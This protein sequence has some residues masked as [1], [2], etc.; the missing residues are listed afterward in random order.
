MENTSHASKP[1]ERTRPAFAVK[2][3]FGILGALGEGLLC[4]EAKDGQVVLEP[5]IE[6]RANRQARLQHIPWHVHVRCFCV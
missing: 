2:L 5:W 1:N 3:G 6:R 4:P